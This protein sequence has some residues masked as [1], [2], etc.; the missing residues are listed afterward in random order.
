[1]QTRITFLK[2]LALSMLIGCALPAFAHDQGGA[3]AS[4]PYATQSWLITCYDDGNGIAA[5]LYFDVKAS[6]P[7]RKFGVTAT[8][9][10]NG[11]EAS[12]TDSKS[13]DKI[14]SPVA[15][16]NGGDG[17][18]VITLSKAKARDNQP[19][20]IL[21]G[22]MVYGFTYHCQSASGAHTGTLIN[23]Y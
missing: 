21:K 19:D 13:G 22:T 14:R 11:V 3:L 12:T 20:S 7:S 23:R 9:F 6:T 4:S 5:A 10:K 17:E 15:I 2:P 18:Y 8:V 1:M 16:L